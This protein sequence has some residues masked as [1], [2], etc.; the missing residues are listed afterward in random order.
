MKRFLLHTAVLF[1]VSF[2]AMAQ[3]QTATTPADSVA[4]TPR[5]PIKDLSSVSENLEGA[6]ALGVTEGIAKNP[7]LLNDR[8]KLYRTENMWT[9]L[10]LDTCTGRVWQVQYAINEDSR[11]QSQF[12]YT[13]LDWGDSWNELDNIGR[14]ELYPTQNMYNFLLMDKKIGRIWQIQW[15]TNPS[16][17][18]VVAEIE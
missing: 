6:V 11:M 15:S 2:S 7:N 3:E 10:K 5:Y 12:V 1:A 13:M 14:F 16:S 17:R 4:V 18:G 8:Y 9:F